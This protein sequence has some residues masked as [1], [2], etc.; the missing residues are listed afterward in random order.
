V[1]QRV[2]AKKNNLR[3]ARLELGFNQTDFAH[4]L[5]VVYKKPVTL[6]NY[7]K[8]ELGVRG[9]EVQLANKIAQTVN[10]KIDYLFESRASVD[11]VT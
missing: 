3:K 4:L 7:S 8:Y 6:Q 1:I 2:Y 10:K 9:I 11:Y 5:T